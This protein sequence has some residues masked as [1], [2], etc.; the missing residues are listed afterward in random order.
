MG[1]GKI[2]YTK[3]LPAAEKAGVQHYFLEDET[4][5]PL[6]SIPASFKYL[7]ALQLR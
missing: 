4:P 2:D 1:T 3:I 5:T 6:Q 7:R